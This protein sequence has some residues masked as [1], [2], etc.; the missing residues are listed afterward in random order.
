MVGYAPL[1]ILFVCYRVSVYVYVQIPSG[2]AIMNFDFDFDYTYIHRHRPCALPHV[3]RSLDMA[4]GGLSHVVAR[5]LSL[6][7]QLSKFPAELLDS[8]CVESHLVKL[9]ECFSEWQLNLSTTLELTAVEVRDIEEE[10]QNP[11][12]RRVEMFRRW[13]NKLASTGVFQCHMCDKNYD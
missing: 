6:E 7:E 8:L 9:T 2:A 12:R 11:A 10:W 1:M 4:E 13:R 5:P 3:T